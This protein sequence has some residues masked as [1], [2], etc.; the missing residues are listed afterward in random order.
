M[1]YDVIFSCILLKF[2]KNYVL[3]VNSYLLKVY[4]ISIKC[5]LSLTR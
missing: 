1:K 5:F 2:Y 4:N 3:K